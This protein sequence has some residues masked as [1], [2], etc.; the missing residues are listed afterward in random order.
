MH[1]LP[2]SLRLL[3]IQIWPLSSRNSLCL[4]TTEEPSDDLTSFWNVAV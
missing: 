1:L 2:T 3:N 4:I